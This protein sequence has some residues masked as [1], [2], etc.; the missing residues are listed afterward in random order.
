MAKILFS[1]YSCFIKTKV[2]YLFIC[3]LSVIMSSTTQKVVDQFA[4]IF[5]GW[6]GTTAIR[7]WQY[8][9]SVIFLILTWMLVPFGSSMLQN[10]LEN[11][12]GQPWQIS[13]QFEYYLINS[14]LRRKLQCLKFQ[15]FNC[16][17]DCF[18]FFIT[19]TMCLDKNVSDMFANRTDR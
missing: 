19:N 12:H 6:L 5:D 4:Q 8:S 9:E 17:P 11:F 16:S 14:S 15:D 10:I 1:M 18:I 3:P 7:F 13:A 2:V